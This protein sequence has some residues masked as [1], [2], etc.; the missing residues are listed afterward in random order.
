MG[1]TVSLGAGALMRGTAIASIDSNSYSGRI[2]SAS[3]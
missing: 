2:F 3:H 1:G